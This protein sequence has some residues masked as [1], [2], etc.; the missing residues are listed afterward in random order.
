[1]SVW[2]SDTGLTATFKPYVGNWT[3]IKDSVDE[4]EDTV[5]ESPLERIEETQ[6]N[7]STVFD[8]TGS[9]NNDDGNFFPTKREV[10]AKA[11]KS[12]P[13]TTPRGTYVFD[14]ETWQKVSK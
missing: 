14:G 6:D 5:T 4:L 2:K 8:S 12:R 10:V 11:D 9:D 1:M 3:L 7:T 13:A